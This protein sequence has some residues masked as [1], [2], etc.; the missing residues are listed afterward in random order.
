MKGTILKKELKETL[1]AM[2]GI[3]WFVIVSVLFSILCLAVVS[4]KELSLMAQTEVILSFCKLAVGVGVVVSIILA[5]VSFSHEREAETLE[6]LLLTPISKWQLALG[7]LAAVW[8]MSL[9]VYLIA[10]PY[11]LGVGYRSGTALTAILLLLGMGLIVTIAYSMIAFSISILLGNSKNALI[12]SIIVTVITALPSFLSTTT[13]K[14]GFAMILNKISPASSTFNVLK[15]IV[16]NKHGVDVI[17]PFLIPIAIF[18]L[19]SILFLWF[20]IGKI[21]YQRGQ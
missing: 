5:S 6:A 4:V 1:L 10:I 2:K 21:S 17:L 9:G 7:K 12:V 8:V 18:S 3:I 15:E 19:F 11:I 16:V 13:K 20:S 14:A